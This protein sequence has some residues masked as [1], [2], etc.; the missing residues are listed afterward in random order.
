MKIKMIYFASL[1]E[2][3][4]KSSEEIETI[5]QTATELYQFIKEKYQLQLNQEQ[6]K[7]AINEVYVDFGTTLKEA[8]TIVFIP[9]VAGG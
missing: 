8:D 3:I 2:T 6:L 7:V 1:R 5:A 9:P 4:G